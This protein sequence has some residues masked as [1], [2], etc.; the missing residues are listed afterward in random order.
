[1]PGTVH[2]PDVPPPVVTHFAGNKQSGPAA[3]SQAAPS[4]AGA[5]HVPWVWP[6]GI[7]HAAPELQRVI[8]VP[9]AP[10]ASL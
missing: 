1:M 3:V 8:V 6:G 2:V 10:H 7:T 4:A 9:T 5:M